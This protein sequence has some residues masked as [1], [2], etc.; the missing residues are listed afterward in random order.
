MTNLRRL[1]WLYLWLLIFEGALRKWIVPSL[2]APLL[3][4]RDPV[5]MAIYFLALRHGLTFR[6][7]PFFMPNLMLAVLTAGTATIFGM[8]NP[9]V[10]V[11]G[12]RTDYLQIP[13]IFLLPQIIDR[14]DVIAM[15]RFFMWAAIPIGILAV[16]QFRSS[17][18]SLLNKGAMGTHYGT[19]RPSGVFSFVSGLVN[20]FDLT[21]AFV[22]F[23]YIRS[24]TYKIWL[25]A[26]ATVIML[27]AAACSGSRACLVSMGLVAAIA[28][29]C[30]LIRGRGGVGILVAAVLIFAG[31]LVLS[32]LPVFQEGSEQLQRRFEDAGRFEGDTEGFVDRF[33]GGFLVP[34]SYLPEIPF[35]GNGLGLGTNGASAM[36][37]G[38]R[39]F[40]GPESEWGRLL[41]ECGMVLGSLLC[42]F[43]TL[44]FLVI[45]WRA[46]TVIRRGNF[47]PALIYSACGLVILNGQWGVPTTLG[48]AIF[49][50][51]LTLAACEEPL[52]EE[53]EDEDHD[54][55]EEDEP[56]RSDAISRT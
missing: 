3:V 55:G 4:I 5:V 22:L 9:I 2:D 32:T 6:N 12:L 29:M 52:E 30:V 39:E 17:P 10:T 33:F 41:W 34:F 8:G 7:N 15:G 31:F 18:E 20:F 37:H 48:F 46:F 27:L 50:G 51:G 54:E 35:W 53:D 13:L 1:V 14:D 25:L 47:L 42:L 40:I 49:G 19:V 56:E 23:G 11:Y 45:G 36:L 16:L 24:G 26:A 43:R 38:D 44:L 28:I 21:F